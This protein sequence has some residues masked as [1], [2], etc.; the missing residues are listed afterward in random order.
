MIPR[1]FM[2]D[3]DGLNCYTVVKFFFVVLCHET[4]LFNIKKH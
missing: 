1:S 2:N 4:Y 3:I